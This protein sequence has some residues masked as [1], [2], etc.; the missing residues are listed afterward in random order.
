MTRFTLFFTYGLLLCAAVA[1]A[2][3]VRVVTGSNSYGQGYMFLDN[4]GICKVATAGHVVKLADGR[5]V[6][7][8]TI[9]DER[10][11]T[12]ELGAPIVLSAD[13]DIAVLPVIGA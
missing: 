8:I 4:D 3:V 9:V 1:Q 12:P 6:F 13:P 11:H 7:R 10:G 2:G 5:V